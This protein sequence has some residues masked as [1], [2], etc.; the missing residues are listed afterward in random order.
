[1]LGPVLDNETS[2]IGK[3]ITSEYKIF[4][5]Y[6]IKLKNQKIKRKG[7]DEVLSSLSGDKI[8]PES[9]KGAY[10]TC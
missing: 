2:G 6:M 9:L 1:M 3:L 7:I 4:S 10:E 8:D 5:G